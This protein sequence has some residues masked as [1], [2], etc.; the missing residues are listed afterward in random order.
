[1]IKEFGTFGEHVGCQNLRQIEILCNLCGDVKKMSKNPYAGRIW[2]ASGKS[3]FGTGLDLAWIFV[4]LCHE[5]AKHQVLD[6]P[7][8]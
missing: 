2:A 6:Q 3:L 5:V 7:R 1:M 4:F 8:V